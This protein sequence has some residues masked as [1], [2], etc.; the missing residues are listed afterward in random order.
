MNLS[1]NPNDHKFVIGDTVKIVHPEDR[2]N[3]NGRCGCVVGTTAQFLYI[4][5]T[6]T[7]RQREEKVKKMSKYVERV[8]DS[9]IE[10]FV[11]AK[12]HESNE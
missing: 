9:S 6:R 7:S 10:S 4:V 1:R 5:L 11:L 12:S 2:N 3:N 8:V